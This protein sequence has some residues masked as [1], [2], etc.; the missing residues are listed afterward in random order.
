MRTTLFILVGVA[1]AGC[2]SPKTPSLEVNQKR[3]KELHARIGKAV[4]DPVR[5]QAMQAIIDDL[6]R[7]LQVHLASLHQKRDTIV[8]ASSEYATTRQDLEVLYA[9]VNTEMREVYLHL[10]E[11]YMALTEQATPEEWAAITR[12]KKRLFEL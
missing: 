8:T 12:G 3:I 7:Q 5:A 2:S 1:L 4:A 6:D 11:A 9:D 10:Q